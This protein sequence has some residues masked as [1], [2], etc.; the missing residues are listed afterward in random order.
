MF[1]ELM[2]VIA[3]GFG[4]A[5]IGMALRHLSGDAIPRFLTPALSGL[6]MFAF[7]IWAEYSWFARTAGGL[8]T[9]IEIVSA[10]AETSAMRPWTYLAPMTTRFS[11]V[12]LAGARRNPA[13]PDQV[14]VEA[15]L[16]ERFRAIVRAPMLIDCAG[17]RRADIADGAAFDAQGRV[18]DPDWGAPDATDPLIVTVCREK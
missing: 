9:G 15:L 2:A 18:V 17:A 6:G 13:A 3:I 11:A 8:P 10:S 4:G 7:A 12:D 16:F 14:M 1:Y 5:G